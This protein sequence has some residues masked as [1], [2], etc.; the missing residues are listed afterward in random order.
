MPSGKA[1]AIRDAFR[2]VDKSDLVLARNPCSK[3]GFT[4]VIEVAGGMFQARM[5]VKG[6]GRGGVRKRRQE[7]L[8]GLFDSAQEAAEFLAIIKRDGSQLGLASLNEDGAPIKQNKQHK[9]RAKPQPAAAPPL[10]ERMQLPMATTLGVP[11]P[12]PVLHAPIVAASL[13]PM[14]PLGYTPPFAAH[15]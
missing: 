14:Q 7:S 10:T 2:F 12:F 1:A 6:D 5:Q 9:P 8:G 4:G 11:L 3:T 15:M 13:M